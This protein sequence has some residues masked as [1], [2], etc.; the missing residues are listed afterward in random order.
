[1]LAAAIGDAVGWPIENRSGRVG[2]I[3]KVKP[4]LQ[5]VGWTRREGGSYAPHE[6][7]VEAGSYSD[8]T[9]LTLAAGRSR[10]RGSAW[11]KHWTDCELP[12]WLVY[13]RGG[14]GATK[15][16]AQA[17]N[18][19]QAPWSGEQKE[20]DRNRYFGAGGNGVAMRIMPHVLLDGDDEF[21][22]VASHILAD[23][24]CTHGHPRALV[25]AL[26]YGY[27]LW[28]ALRQEG[29]L[30]FGDL[31]AQTL[32]GE[33]QWGSIPELLPQLSDWRQQI[34]SGQAQF[35]KAW[36]RTRKEMHD[37][38]TLCRD[39]LGQG[40]LAVDRKALEAIG[41]FDKRTNGAGTIAAAASVYL[42]S[43]YASQPG[44]GL[45]AAAFA[46]GADT[47]TIA[48][49]TGGLLGAIDNDAWLSRLSTG[50]QDVEYIEEVAAA[51][52]HDRFQER[53]RG[54]T[55]RQ[56]DRRELLEALGDDNRAKVELP[57]FG[58]CTVARKHELSTKSSNL[59]REWTL[60]TE[61]GQTLFIKRIVPTKSKR[62]TTNGHAA[63]KPPFWLV[64]RVRDL[65][66]SESFYCDVFGFN[67]RKGETPERTYL[68]D[69]IALELTA[70]P[71]PRPTEATDEKALLSRHDTI[72]LFRNERELKELHQ[73]LV[74]REGPVSG[75]FDRGSF[76]AFRCTDPD[77][78][79][80]EVRA[81]STP[82]PD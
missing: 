52:A 43:R 73:R 42:A 22:P 56:P 30:G 25:G 5:L 71:G 41:A 14:G 16:A 31:V 77:G 34:G 28:L 36:D 1:M 51:L 11:W 66:A 4:R 48:A 18:R 19:G 62:S 78:T 61:E 70:K 9:Q 82:S 10:L 40:S 68:S 20:A 6:V 15:R 50:L 32:A 81:A 37:L 3:S 33:D 53:P 12:L 44:Q 69:R 75:I 58:A 38:L 65:R 59:I 8:D 23:G 2:G 60:L 80:I 13:E 17:W 46:K 47:D 72:T 64:L 21:N 57:V 49:M 29:P 45:T 79:V 74:A 35:E 67:K 24:V 55:W 7:E 63:A 54:R 39:S 27:A 76:R 26:A